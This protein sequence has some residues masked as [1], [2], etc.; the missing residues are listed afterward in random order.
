[1]DFAHRAFAAAAIRARA[2]ALKRFRAFFFR[3]ALRL[4][5]AAGVGADTLVPE[6]TSADGVEA[7]NDGAS[8]MPKTSAS[9][10]SLR[11]GALLGVTTV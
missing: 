7:G 11:A 5:T 4:P 6:G 8:S 1:M 3:G 10:D 9:S 2:A